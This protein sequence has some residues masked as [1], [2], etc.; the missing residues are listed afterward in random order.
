MLQRDGQDWMLQRDG[1]DWMFQ[2]DGLEDQV[3]G[4]LMENAEMIPGGI[5][6]GCGNALPPSARAD[7]CSLS[8]MMTC[9]F[10]L[11]AVQFM[12]M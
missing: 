11:Q 5:T 9:T 12:F 4:W 3:Q 2:R 6:G 8:E 10:Q 1:Q 7:L